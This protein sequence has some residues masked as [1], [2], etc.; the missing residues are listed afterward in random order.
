MSG[1]WVKSKNLT[2]KGAPSDAEAASLGTT[3]RATVGC[4]PGGSTDEIKLCGSQETR[5]HLE[6]QCK[7]LDRKRVVQEEPNLS[8]HAWS[9]V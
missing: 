4:R 1:S 2:F 9:C 5:M 3:V 8:H 7:N 6:E